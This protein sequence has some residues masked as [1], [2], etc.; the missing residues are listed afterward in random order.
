MNAVIRFYR[1]VAIEHLINRDARNGEDKSVVLRYFDTA[2]LRAFLMS[3]VTTDI[4][5]PNRAR[6]GLRLEDGLL[7][8]TKQHMTEL[9]QFAKDNVSEELFLMLSR[10][11]SIFAA[12][13]F[14]LWLPIGRISAFLERSAAVS[15]DVATPTP[16]RSGGHAFK[17]W[18]VITS[19]TNFTATLISG[20]WH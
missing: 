5:I 19:R 15:T 8:L 11:A 17:P 20:T 2:R 13:S 3:Q 14:S 10:S 9:L 12:R 18:L 7:P 6:P 4:S 1:C 16:T